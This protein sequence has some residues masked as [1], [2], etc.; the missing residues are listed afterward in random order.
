VGQAAGFG[1]G[2]GAIDR[3]LLGRFAICLLTG[4]LLTGRLLGGLFGRGRLSP[5]AGRLLGG[6]LRRRGLQIRWR[7]RFG[8][9]DDQ[10]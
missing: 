9:T 5:G 6:N 4:R 3:R 1:L 2:R 10:E 7:G 8:T